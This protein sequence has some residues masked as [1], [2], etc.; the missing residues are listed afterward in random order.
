M[1]NKKPISTSDSSEHW[2]YSVWIDLLRPDITANLNISILKSGY[3]MYAY[4]LGVIIGT[5]L[6]AGAAKYLPPKR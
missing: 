6:L 2:Y 5:I 4:A 1:A 3:R